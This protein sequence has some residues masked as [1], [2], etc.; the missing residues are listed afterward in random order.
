MIALA[1]WKGNVVA[2][3]VFLFTGSR[4]V[5]KFGASDKEF[6]ELRANNLIMFE[7]IQRA[8][9]EGFTT[10]D[11][12]RT[13][14]ENEGLRQFKN[15]WGTREVPLQYFRWGVGNHSWE[16]QS[17]NSNSKVLKQVFQKLPVPALKFIGRIMYGHMG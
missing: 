2:G 13:E 16:I 12:G 14:P 17:S 11:F 3:A 6:Q 5:F 15:G 10:F 7:A 9:R 4:F 1:S 8:C